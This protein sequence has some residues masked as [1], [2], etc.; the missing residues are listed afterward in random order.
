MELILERLGFEIT[1]DGITVCVWYLRS[2]CLLAADVGGLK[3]LNGH[4]RLLRTPQPGVLF[5]PSAA[6]LPPGASAETE[7]DCG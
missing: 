7:E 4:T 1:G 3:G 6:I 2:I 5:L